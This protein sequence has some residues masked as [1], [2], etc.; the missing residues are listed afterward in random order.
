MKL[1]DTLVHMDLLDEYDQSQRRYENEQ[2]QFLDEKEQH[3][4]IEIINCV[5]KNG[6]NWPV[7]NVWNKVWNSWLTLCCQTDLHQYSFGTLEDTRDK[8]MPSFINK[9][10]TAECIQKIEENRPISRSMLVDMMTNTQP[11]YYYDKDK[12]SLLYI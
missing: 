7:Y 1:C 2:S 3:L 4:L 8:F 12:V 6:E 11:Y 9:W 10:K 5:Q